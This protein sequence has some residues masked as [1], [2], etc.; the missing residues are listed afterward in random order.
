MRDNDYFTWF[1]IAFVG[2]TVDGGWYWWV[3]ATL[4]MVMSI[5]TDLK[6]WRK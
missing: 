4:F 2:A 6:E 3:M 1:L 5:L